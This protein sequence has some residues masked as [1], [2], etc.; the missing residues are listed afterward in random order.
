MKSLEKE[1]VMTSYQAS[2]QNQRLPKGFVYVP[3]GS[4]Q[5]DAS[6]AAHDSESC[7]VQEPGG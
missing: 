1:M 3:V 7:E 5:K 2:L 4:L 6:S